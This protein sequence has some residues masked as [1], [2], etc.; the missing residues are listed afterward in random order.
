MEPRF[1]FAYELTEA[2]KC[3]II[4]TKEERRTR[5]LPLVDNIMHICKKPIASQTNNNDTA[6]VNSAIAAESKAL[7]AEAKKGRRTLLK[8][9][10]IT[11]AI[12]FF[13]CFVVLRIVLVSGSSMEPTLHSGEVL[14]LNHIACNPERGDVVVAKIPQLNKKQIIK[15]VIAVAGDTIDIDYKTGNVYVNGQKQNEPYIK[16]MTKTDLGT[17][18]PMTVPDGFVFLMGDNRNNSYDSRAINI[19]PVSTEDI[20]G[21]LFFK[22]S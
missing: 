10:A 21:E 17:P 8:D 5:G 13:L 11:A 12:V 7:S 16:A 19:G 15:R 6:E 22:L 2:R 18:L 14:I 1:P 4:F 3:G 9:M 20:I